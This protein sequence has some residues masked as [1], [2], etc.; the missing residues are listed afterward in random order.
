[1]FEH[2]PQVNWQPMQTPPRVRQRR[3]EF[4]NEFGREVNNLMAQDERER[5]LQPS[6]SWLNWHLRRQCK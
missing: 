4:N 3:Q 6:G 1:M 2:P 5:A